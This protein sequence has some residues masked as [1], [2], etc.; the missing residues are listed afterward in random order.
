[1]NV[2]YPLVHRLRRWINRKTA[3]IQCRVPARLLRNEPHSNKR[4]SLKQY[5]LNYVAAL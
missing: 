4:N 5:G 2:G 3:L 1:M